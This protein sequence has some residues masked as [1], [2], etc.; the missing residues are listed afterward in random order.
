MQALND[1]PCGRLVPAVEGQSAFVPHPLP[2][3]LDMSSRLSYLLEQATLAVGTLAGVG[4]TAPNPRLFIQP[5]I[6]REAVLSSRIEGTQAS[7]SDLFRHESDGQIYSDDVL[8]VSN[9][10]TA[11]EYGIDRLARL[12]ISLRLINEVHERLL[13]GVRG[14]DKRP[15]ELRDEQVWIGPP[16]S[17]IKNARFIPPPPGYVRDLLYDWEKFANERMDMPVLVR[18][19]LMHYQIEAIHPYRDGN[20][21]I[22]RLLIIL[23][24]QAQRALP[25]PLLYMSAYFERDRQRYYDELLNVSVNCDW[26]RWL[27]Y[28]LTGV[29]R[30]A[31]DTL[32]RLRRVRELHTRYREALITR[33]GAVSG[34]NLLDALFDNPFMTVPRAMG[35]LDMTPSGA[36]RVLDRLIAAGIVERID[37]AWRHLYVAQGILNEI[38]GPVESVSNQR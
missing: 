25:A 22:G 33:R 30:E 29:E 13:T 16:G 12:P 26:E 27:D 35:I 10:V 19:A 6:R 15:G 23:F 14:Q 11:L 3:Q 32:E 21:R 5:F 28:F 36:R 8:E 7:L 24:L 17:S 9:Y 37:D 20:G 4:E 2:R 1:N 38:E 18:C 34:L 31:R